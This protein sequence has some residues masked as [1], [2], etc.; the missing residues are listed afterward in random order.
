[1]PSELMSKLRL[2]FTC[3]TTLV[4]AGH[5][6]LMNMNIPVLFPVADECIQEGIAQAARSSANNDVIPY[7][8]P[9][10]L[11]LLGTNLMVDYSTP[12]V[13]FHDEN[14]SARGYRLLSR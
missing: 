12:E 5:A 4:Y 10:H 14:T 1:M 2:Y 13:Q 9:I 7:Q 11:W 8:L 6:I 3:T